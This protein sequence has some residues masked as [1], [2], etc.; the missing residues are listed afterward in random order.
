MRSEQE[1]DGVTILM[2]M[3]LS[4]DQKAE[5]PHVVT[6]KR[7]SYPHYDAGQGPTM[8]QMQDYWSH[9]EGVTKWKAQDAGEH[10]QD[11]RYMSSQL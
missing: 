2:E 11:R 4:E 5:I 9:Q 1:C 6:F 7:Y 10:Y 8:P 3:I